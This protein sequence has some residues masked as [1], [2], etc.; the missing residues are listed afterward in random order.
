MDTRYLVI[1]LGFLLG[2]QSCAPCASVDFQ[3]HCCW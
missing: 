3:A 1:D 2:S